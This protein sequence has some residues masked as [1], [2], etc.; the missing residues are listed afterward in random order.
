MDVFPCDGRI[1]PAKKRR[2]SDSTRGRTRK[3]LARRVGG[4]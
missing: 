2:E 3:E 1:P 4:A